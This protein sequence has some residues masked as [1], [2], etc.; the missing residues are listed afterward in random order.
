M[1]VN[2]RNLPMLQFARENGCP[3]SDYTK[4]RAFEYLGYVE[5]E[6]AA[7]AAAAAAAIEEVN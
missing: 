2:R 6:G 5:E 3:W 4:T 1:A 7:G